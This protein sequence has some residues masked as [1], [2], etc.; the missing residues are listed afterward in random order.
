MKVVTEGNLDRF[1]GE[2][3]G[4]KRSLGGVGGTPLERVVIESL[5]KQFI[6]REA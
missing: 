6:Q 1:L 3:H 4:R 5:E 2:W